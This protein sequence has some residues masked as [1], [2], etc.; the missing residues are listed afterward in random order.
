VAPALDILRQV[1]DLVMQKDDTAGPPLRSGGP[2]PLGSAPILVPWCVNERWTVSQCAGQLLDSVILVLPQS[3]L[4]DLRA[5]E[6]RKFDGET[7]GAQGPLHSDPVS[8]TPA[9]SMRR[10]FELI[11]EAIDSAG[12]QLA[13]SAGL[14]ANAP[15]PSDERDQ[16][17]G[18]RQS[19]E[20][21]TRS[22]LEEPESDHGI[23]PW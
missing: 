7:D 19:R 6:P 4:G 2:G 13:R 5:M 8:G 9:W 16:P 11:D 3:S 18:G 1:D 20:L 12:A 10:L 15:S 22:R 14:W 17:T 21:S 23:S